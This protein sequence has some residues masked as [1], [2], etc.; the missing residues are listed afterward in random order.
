MIK[1]FLKSTTAIEHIANYKHQNTRDRIVCKDGF[2][3]SVQAGSGL[4]CSPRE[5]LEDGEYESVEIGFPSC[6]ESLIN[7]YAE[8]PSDYTDTVYG[9]VPVEIVDEVIIKHGGLL[10]PVVKI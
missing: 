8:N 1:E 3:M 2:S 10:N 6:E 5:C 7:T 4:Y 9:Y